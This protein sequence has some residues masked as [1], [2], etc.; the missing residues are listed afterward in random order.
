VASKA[1]DVTSRWSSVIS[2]TSAVDSDISS[3]T[4]DTSSRY[5]CLGFRQFDA[6]ASP[7]SLTL[8]PRVEAV[9]CSD[10]RKL[11]LEARSVDDEQVR[12]QRGVESVA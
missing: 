1:I 4:F 2:D 11:G 10:E 7:L 6:S 9:L 12:F 8:S 5:F 3:M